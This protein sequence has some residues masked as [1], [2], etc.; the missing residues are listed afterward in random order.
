MKVAPSIL[1]LDYTD[2]RNQ[3]EIINRKTDIIHF[4]VMDGHFVP[5]LSFG[6]DIFRAFRLNSDLFLD[7]HLMV[8]DPDFFSD[9]FIKA[10]ADGVTFHYEAFNSDYERIEML[11]KLKSRYIRAGIAIK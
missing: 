10:G 5:N 8:D 2:F 6:P 9:V 11:K 1:S 7:V 4:D 3:L